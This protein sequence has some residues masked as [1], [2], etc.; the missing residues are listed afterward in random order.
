MNMKKIKICGINSAS[1]F[2]ATVEAEADY[3][4]FVFFGA[5]PRHVTP[6]QAAALAAQRPGGPKHV[7]LFVA[8]D[9]AAVAVALAALPLDIL[10]V[11]ADAARCRALRRHFDVA[12]WRAIGVSSTADLP[13]DDEGLDGF[14]IEA[15]QPVGATRPGGNAVAM[16]WSLLAGWQAPTFWLL[17]G[18]LN[19][20]N[21]AAAI[22]A[23]KPPA[24]D[25][26]S[27]VETAPGIKSP[28]LIRAFVTAA[29]E[30][31]QAVLF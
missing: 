13:A 7:G 2:D 24:V 11:Y 20:G 27:G 5:S 26:S 15:K 4:G 10:Q 23:A 31:K 6:A 25:V 12:V 30:K 18:G 1:A 8:P 17:G 16:D 3:L 22:A 28:K 19:A 14:V 21:I 29:R 9:D